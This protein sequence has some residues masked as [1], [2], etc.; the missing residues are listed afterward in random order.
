[1]ADKVFIEGLCVITTIGAYDWEQT[2]KQKLVLDIEM[3]WDNKP[4]GLS[5]D[6]NQCL[7]YAQVSQQV[8]VHIENN[9]FALIE[10]VAEEVAALLIKQFSIPWVKIK[11]SKPGAVAA[12]KN[13]AVE[14]TR[15]SC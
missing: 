10:R 11:V 14:I 9:N 7:D 5:D 4:A 12:A 13:V 3:E 2:I 1:M 6:V 8:I 15:K